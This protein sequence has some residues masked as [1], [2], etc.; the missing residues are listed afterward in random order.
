MFKDEKR[1]APIIHKDAPETTVGWYF[2]NTYEI[3]MSGLGYQLVWWLFE[4]DHRI[5]VKRGFLDMSEPGIENCQLLGFTVS[6]ELDFINILK[7]LERHGIPACT[8]QRGTPEEH[9]LVFGGGPVLSANPEPFAQFFDVILLGDAEAMVPSFIDAWERAKHC[10]SRLECLKELS[11]PPGIYVPSLY[12]ISYEHDCGP[13]KE[14]KSISDDVPN[15]VAKQVFAAPDD[16]AA[17]TQI[18]SSAT[19]WSDTFLIEVVR[20]CPQECRFCLASYLTR[21]FRATTVDT[22]MEKI[23]T[24]LRHTKRVGLLGPSVTEH[25]H[26]D[27]LAKRLLA[28]PDIDLTIA[29]VR[30]DSLTEDILATLKE[31]G[32]RSVTIAIESGSE[33]LRTIMKKNL[34]EA[35]ICRAVEL[36]DQ[37]G[38]SGVKFYGIVGLPHETQEDLEETVRLLTMLKKKHRRLKFVFGVS[39]FVPKAQTPF[40]WNGRDK[41]CAPK[42]EYLRKNLAKLGIEMRPESLNWSDIQALISRGDRRLGPLLLEISR[43]PG[44]HGAWKRLLRNLPPATPDLD[45]YAFRTIPFDEPLPWHHL[46]D[47]SR[48]DYLQKH[49]RTAAQEAVQIGL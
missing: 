3:G 27:Q 49:D 16:Y 5:D 25:P 41:G 24:A 26:F 46:V 22:I 40:Q 30:A 6:W 21:P 2:P 33:R 48:T 15:T 4:Q 37:S 12:E 36:I 32:Q 42:L 31:L 38:L 14:I 34:S 43:G 39:S 19:A 44:N 8:D 23:D 10:K 9:P 47:K 17:H 11:K 13:I 18:L 7:V 1:L 29:S 45:Y 20:S 28:T 35:E